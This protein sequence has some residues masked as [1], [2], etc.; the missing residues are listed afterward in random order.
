M[1]SKSLDSPELLLLRRCCA[2][3]F[4]GGDLPEIG[5]LG[6][7]DWERFLALARRH[8]VQGLCWR[9]IERLQLS[10]PQDV[11]A[12]FQPERRAIAAEGLRALAVSRELLFTF[13][14]A[15][16]P[17]L[18]LKGLTVGRLAYG[19]PFLKMGWDIDILVSPADL[20]AAALL[21]TRLGYQPAT[22]PNVHAIREWHRNA[23]ESVWIKN[24]SPPVELH[25]RLVDN[26]ELLDRLDPFAAPRTVEVVP[27]VRLATLGREELFA[28]LAVHG[29]SSAWFRLKWLCDFAALLAVET[30]GEMEALHRRALEL[31]A[32]RASAWAL[33]LCQRLFGIAH[34][35]VERLGLS[36]ELANRRLLQLGLAELAD[37][38][39]PTQQFLGTARIHFA[40]LLLKPGL[41]FA[42]GEV[43]RQVRA[44]LR[45]PVG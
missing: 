44:M 12:A 7:I 28:Y 29:A 15:G 33:L 23:K 34:D 10:P 35:V 11:A 2:A 40:Q 45:D 27:G 21:L 31:G 36:N 38:M 19:D 25:T 17:L 14:E 6:S 41:G 22:P 30:S 26:P 13:S 16:V 37:E 3:C 32:G 20:P 18:F 1:S 39:E 24:G 43:R 42:A 4:G 8:R 9:G 5:D